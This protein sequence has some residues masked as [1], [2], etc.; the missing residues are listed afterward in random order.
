[1]NYLL[2]WT[3]KGARDGRWFNTFEDALNWAIEWENDIFHVMIWEI[4]PEE[5]R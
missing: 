1:M 4:T 5:L 2:N 3:F